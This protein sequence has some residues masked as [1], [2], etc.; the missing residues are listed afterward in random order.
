MFQF[1]Y[2]RNSIAEQTPCTLKTTLLLQKEGPS[3]GQCHR[4]AQMSPLYPDHSSVTLWFSSRHSKDVY[5]HAVS[6]PFTSL[7]IPNQKAVVL[8][9]SIASKILFSLFRESEGSLVHF[10]VATKCGEAFSQVEGQ[11]LSPHPL[12]Y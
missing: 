1:F 4:S 8:V 2:Y 5:A 11:E 9:H 12:I 7:V 3:H 6:K 10:R